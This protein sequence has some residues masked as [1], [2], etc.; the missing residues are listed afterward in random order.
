MRNNDII[1]RF[2]SFHCSAS[3][4]IAEKLDAAR[5]NDRPILPSLFLFVSDDYIT[6]FIFTRRSENVPFHRIPRVILNF[7]FGLFT[8]HFYHTYVHVRAQR[9]LWQ[10]DFEI[11]ISQFRSAILYFSFFSSNSIS[12]SVF[13]SVSGTKK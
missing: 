1:S 13:P 7:G 2:E 3:S 12:S 4:R 6:T 10:G 8:I 9:Q 5:M 11:R